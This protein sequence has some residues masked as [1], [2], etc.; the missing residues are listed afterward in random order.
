MSH[1][2]REAP[3]VRPRRQVNPPAY[4][5]DYELSGPGLRRQQPSS[6]PTRLYRMTNRQVLQVTPDP[7]LQSAKHQ[8][9]QNGD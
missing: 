2:E 7:L 8:I 4:F 1:P 9:V 3:A 6:L 5:E